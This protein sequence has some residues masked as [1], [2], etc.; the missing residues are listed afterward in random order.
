ML[1]PP[2]FGTWGKLKM[3]WE[4]FIYIYVC[5]PGKICTYFTLGK[6]RPLGILRIGCDYVTMAGQEF[7]PAVMLFFD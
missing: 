7:F 2:D 3:S 6:P 5:I 1:F 4:V